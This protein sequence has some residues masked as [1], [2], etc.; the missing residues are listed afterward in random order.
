MRGK[1]SLRNFP[2]HLDINQKEP[3]GTVCG[4]GSGCADNERRGVQE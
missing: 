4:G 2:R 1:T 3:A